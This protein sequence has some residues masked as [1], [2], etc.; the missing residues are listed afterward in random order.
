MPH[1][2]YHAEWKIVMKSRKQTER[3]YHRK[4]RKSI[5]RK[6]TSIKIIL[7]IDFHLI[8]S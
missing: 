6:Y 1:E 7:Q 4:E 3:K 2:G 5:G 8:L